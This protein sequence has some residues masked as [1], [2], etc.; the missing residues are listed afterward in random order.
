MANSL[1]DI[2]LCTSL[3]ASTLNT[4]DRLLSKDTRKVGVGTEALPITTTERRST[5]GTNDGLMSELM[6]EIDERSESLHLKRHEPP[7]P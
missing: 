3:D 2:M 6:L 5:Q 1:T 7:L 4:I